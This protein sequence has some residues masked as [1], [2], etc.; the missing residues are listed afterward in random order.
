[1]G[2]SESLSTIERRQELLG[3]LLNNEPAQWSCPRGDERTIAYHIRECLDI[4]RKNPQAY[5][6]LYLAA[7]RMKVV[8]LEPGSLQAKP[9]RD[10]SLVTVKVGNL[11][12]Q[13]DAKEEYRTVNQIVEHWLK[14]RE[15][16]LRFPET[17]LTTGDLRKLHAWATEQGLLLFWSH[18]AVTIK[19]YDEELAA[20]AFNP[21]EDL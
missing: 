14:Q 11:K 10:D 4:A 21:E 18:P 2:Y 15:S 20:F 16:T 6:D 3:P 8:I 1:M 9:R 13:T 5:P 17:T 7:R 19:K 12:K